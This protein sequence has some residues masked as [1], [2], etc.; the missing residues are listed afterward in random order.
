MSNGAM[1]TYAWA[2]AFPSDLAA[3]APV[4]GTLIASCPS[5]SPMPVF[6]IHGTADRNVPIDGGV[7]PAGV[8]NV[9]Y[10]SLS[11]S[12]AP[13]LSA[14]LC[15]DAPSSSRSGKYTQN[16]W[17]CSGTVEIMT[18]IVDGGAH[19]W[20]EGATNFLWDQLSRHAR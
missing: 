9:S 1:M 15:A 5:P 14:A 11:E 3:I 12:L 10:R 4:A 6:A 19:E 8:T 16:R 20:P 13:F 7:G 17:Q 2:C 18:M